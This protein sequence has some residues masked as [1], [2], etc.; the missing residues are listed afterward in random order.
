MLRKTQRFIGRLVRREEG[1]AF[2]EYALLL[3]LVAVAGIVA[4]S[5]LGTDIS[6]FFTALSGSITGNTP[7]N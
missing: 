3:G 4:L 2:A 6:A 7:G 1:A 5:Q